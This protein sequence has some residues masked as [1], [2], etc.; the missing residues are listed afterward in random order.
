MSLSILRYQR[1]KFTQSVEKFALP[2]HIVR[3]AELATPVKF[4]QRSLSGVAPPSGYVTAIPSQSKGEIFSASKIKTYAECPSKY[5]LRYI[6]GLP[7]PA[8]VPHPVLED[9]E[10]DEMLSGELRGIIVHEVMQKIDGIDLTPNGIRAEVEKQ[11]VLHMKEEISQSSPAVD[12]IT[13]VINAIVTSECWKEVSR[14]QNA[15]TEFTITT[16]LGGDF[17]TGTI[18]RV[19]Q[20]ANGIWNVLDFKTDTI[21]HG[22]FASR[23]EEYAEQLKFYA[24]LV[25]RF[26]SVSHVRATLMFTSM[27]NRPFVET[28]SVAALE[29]LKQEI[30][31][32]IIKIK[33]REFSPRENPCEHCPMLPRGCPRY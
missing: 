11:V 23:I 31:L 26:F 32:A 22:T 4:E 13:S 19:Y 1:E 25:H 21:T 9:E 29:G 2:V 3:A 6:L 30:G 10:S 20:D 18:D 7:D 17:L 8:S 33:N 5:F 16:A 12:E 14:G 24:F 27:V 28:Y 15:K